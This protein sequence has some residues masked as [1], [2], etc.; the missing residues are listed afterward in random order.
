MLQLFNGCSCSEPS[1][2]PKNWDKTGAKLDK[3]WRIQYYFYDPINAPQGKLFILKG[4][5]N[6]FNTLKERRE[7]IKV[8]MDEL[9]YLLQY[10]GFN[11]ITKTRYVPTKSIDI[12][13]TT[14]WLDALK[15]AFGKITV[16]KSTRSDMKCCLKAIAGASDELRLNAMQVSQVRRKHIKLVL[17]HLNSSPHRF[18]KFRSY[19]MSLFKELVE[20]EATDLNP[21]VGISK[22]KT[23]GK[24]REILTHDE[25]IL[26]NNHLKENYYSFW[27][28]MQIFFHSGGRIV[29]L[30]AVKCSD[31]DLTKQRYKTIIKKG[32]QQREA[33]KP[34][35]DIALDLWKEVVATGNETD[36]VFSDGLK[37][38]PRLI[39]YEQ[40]TRRWREH[41]KV[42]LGIK[43]DFYSLKHLNL[44]E[45]AEALDIQA[46]AAMA[47]HTTTVITMKHYALG[48]KERAMDRL[49][50]VSNDFA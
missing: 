46:A 14:K 44:D 19:L 9:L 36:Y 6:R 48:E 30:L 24:L 15:Y 32:S 10:E 20:I 21:V 11:P 41:V 43:A 23:I 1:V 12:E 16:E 42:K 35:K 28:F 17:E 49:R 18:N 25:R 7:G 4:G 29:E 8:I 26:I 38:G 27:R 13:A 40:I 34:I 37:P 39:R 33:W 31:V 2:F 47:G 5:I 3:D 50:K 22:K 45:T